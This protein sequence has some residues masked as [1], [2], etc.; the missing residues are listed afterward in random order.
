MANRIVL[1]KNT[2]AGTA[3]SAS[4][5][6][7]GELAVNTADGAVFTRLESGSVYTLIP[8]SGD[9]IT[10]NTIGAN[11]VTA[12][13]FPSGSYSI[14]NLT[15]TGTLTATVTA[16][17]KLSSARTFQLTGDVTGSVSSDLTSGATISTTLGTVSIA[18]GGTGI[19]TAP[20]TKQVLLGQANGSYALRTLTAGS[21][22]TITESGSTLTIA[23]SG[24]GGGGGAS[25]TISDTS[26]S[27]PSAGNLWWDSS[28]GVLRIYYD[29]GSSSQWVDANSAYVTTPSVVPATLTTST[30]TANQV[31][32]TIP[33]ASYRS[34]KYVVQT[35]SSTSYSVTELLII[36]NGTTAYI[37]EYGTIN[38]GSALVT[39]SA[40]VS[41]GNLRLLATPVNAVTTIKAVPAA[42]AV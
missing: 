11:K 19:T 4:D 24:G 7:P 9:P 35:T 21:N 20:T 39:F 34:V 28:S 2:S 25:V 8:R 42:I 38:T 29:D 15:V 26:P 23:S 41:G 16:A 12:G 40:D 32:D 27:T 10:N 13:T 1:K 3:P 31:V 18:K 33:A 6:V 30:T 36:H 17:Q 37:T 22:V 5:L 14:E